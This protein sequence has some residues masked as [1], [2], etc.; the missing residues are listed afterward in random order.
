MKSQ[1]AK[2]TG[3]HPWTGDQSDER[4]DA[5]RWAAIASAS[6]DAIFSETMDGFIDSWNPGAQ[7][8]FGH[9]ADEVLG[10]PA[11][12]L[13]P[14]G[15]LAEEQQLWLRL[16]SDG[17]VEPYES[18]R[19]KKDGSLITVSATMSA[20]TDAQGRI[21]GTV[22]TLRDISERP[23]ADLIKQRV[24]TRTAQLE[25]TIKDLE[26]FSHSVAHDLRAPLSGIDSF[27]RILL[28]EHGAAM[29]AK[30]LQFLKNIR[31]QTRGMAELIDDL[32]RFSRVSNQRLDASE[33]NM[34]ELAESAAQNL[35]ETR[36]DRIA[37]IKINPLPAACGDRAMVRQVFANLLDNAVKFSS[38]QSA[39]VVEV[40]GRREGEWNVYCVRDNGA[41]F[42]ERHAEK[43]FTAFERLHRKDEFEGTG[44]GLALVQRIVQRHGGEIWAESKVGGGAV[45]YFTLR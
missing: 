34:T 29:D 43:L 11:S 45:F 17:A 32:L 15:R 36:P 24:R 30:G 19:R 20:V 5:R 2:S 16:K 28:E 1:T 3:H 26:A 42:D 35:T 40:S 14:P 41:G 31:K 22:T 7:R 27:S 13:I 37:L 38:R 8:L 39:P 9:A 4:A 33:I 21:M 12:L 23:A 10:R 18:V 25:A 44:V 6:N